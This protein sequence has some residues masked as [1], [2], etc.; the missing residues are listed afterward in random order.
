M[1]F[2]EWIQVCGVVLAAAV[3]LIVAYLH[4]RQMRQIE[5][6]RQDP[7]VGLV[8][9]PHPVV[10]LLKKRYPLLLVPIG[11]FN[12]IYELT[13]Q[14]P[15]TRGSIFWIVLAFATMALGFV[16]DLLIR[17]LTFL[18][19]MVIALIGDSRKPPSSKA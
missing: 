2:R 7:S 9:P 17:I 3:A 6:F 11:V 13:R 15:V 10:V 19:W 14:T 18:G 12:L 5:A 4:R 1:T 8:P 16:A